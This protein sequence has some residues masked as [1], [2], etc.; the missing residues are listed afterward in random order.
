VALFPVSRELNPVA[1][2]QH[3][4]GEKIPDCRLIVGRRRLLTAS[5]QFDA[6]AD[7]NPIPR[8][9]F[10]LEPFETRKDGFSVVR[11]A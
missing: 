5:Q 7:S 6:F 4:N 9:C 1:R 3:L 10:T 8:N 2:V 11:F